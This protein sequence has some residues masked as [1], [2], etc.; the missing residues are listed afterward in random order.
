MAHR[1]DKKKSIVCRFKLDYKMH[2]NGS[3]E[4]EEKEMNQILVLQIEEMINHAAI[5]YYPVILRDDKHIVLIDC[6]Y[7]SSFEPICEALR[8][9]QIDGSDLTHILV[10]HHDHDHL[11]S[12]SMWKKNYPHIQVVASKI[13]APYITGEQ[14]SLRLLQAEEMQK[15]L[16][17]EMQEFGFAFCNLLRSIEP[18][19]VDM[20]VEDGQVMPWAGGCTIL[21]TPGHTTGHISVF[22]PSAKT[23]ITGDAAVL[24]DGKLILANPEFAIDLQEAKASFMK[25]ESLEAKQIIC[26]HGGV[27][28]SQK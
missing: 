20:M 8:K 5:T 4:L 24:E 12:L 9:H 15:T 7:Q 3:C 1:F 22:I 26:Y 14:K 2:E 19:Q 11:G 16:P 6:G 28:D 27:Y 21:L 10:T 17:E 13:E 23:L 18:V 25:L